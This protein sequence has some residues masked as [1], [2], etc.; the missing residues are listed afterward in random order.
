MPLPIT[1]VLDVDDI[2]P[3]QRPTI[4]P[5]WLGRAVRDVCFLPFFFLLKSFSEQEEVYRK[6]ISVETLNLSFVD[7]FYDAVYAFTLASFAFNIAFGWGIDKWANFVQM[8]MLLALWHDNLIYTTMVRAQDGPS[9]FF[10]FLSLLGVLG[11]SVHRLVALEN[12]ESVVQGYVV[13]FL[14]ARFWQIVLFLQVLLSPSASSG[15]K[16]WAFVWAL[17]IALTC[18][19]S[20]VT[21]GLTS[22]SSY[23][24]VMIWLVGCGLDHLVGFVLPL[25]PAFAQL[26]PTRSD[27]QL[28][29]R[30]GAF[31]VFLFANLAV[32]IY[33]S[34]TGIESPLYDSAG[35]Y[36][37][38]ALSVLI[39]FSFLWMYFDS[40]RND[41]EK[42]GS[43]APL[44]R[45]EQTLFGQLWLYSHGP[46]SMAL[47][48]LADASVQIVYFYRGIPRLP[49]TVVPLATGP[50]QGFFWLS[51]SVQWIYGISFAVTLGL[52]TLTGLLYLMQNKRQ[53]M[54]K[55]GRVLGRFALILIMVLM[56]LAGLN[57][58]PQDLDKNGLTPFVQILVGSVLLFVLVAIDW[59]FNILLAPSVPNVPKRTITVNSPPSGELLAQLQERILVQERDIASLRAQLAEARKGA[60]AGGLARGAEDVDRVETEMSSSKHWGFSS[61]T[62]SVVE[63]VVDSSGADEEGD[64]DGA[65]S[66]SYVEAEAPVAGDTSQS[67]RDS[68]PE[69]NVR[70]DEGESNN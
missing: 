15:Q 27:K 41:D 43:T 3:V 39:A 45:N 63:D 22:E 57:D 24:R 1:Q 28:R 8:L 5:F 52:I 32:A 68:D 33:F 53:A 4:L 69:Q 55:Y 2:P 12:F 59:G 21:L 56:P 17:W 30:C 11:M 31:L 61:R 19:P 67:F 48:I 9:R 37:T 7:F 23:V 18:I 13:S 64:G 50:G 10:I 25:I 54:F 14:W 46:L 49:N 20:A 29:D 66:A 16:T 6:S 35:T 44:E 36:A 51:N 34:S 47:V 38:L 62:S 42:Q 40:D 60:A 65:A 26:Q 58:N 70:T